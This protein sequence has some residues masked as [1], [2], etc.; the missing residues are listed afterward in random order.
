[1]PDQPLYT[2]TWPP[3]YTRSAFKHEQPP[4]A[5]QRH[6]RKKA[7]QEQLEE[8]YA[9][10]DTRDA[11]R[12]RATG[13]LVHPRSADPKRRREHHHL[14]GR[15]VRP[16]WREQPERIC[17]VSAFVHDLITRGWIAVEGVDA[18][19]PLFFHWTDLATSHPIK[20]KRSTPVTREQRET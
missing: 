14:R 2:D 7:K 18:S 17:L 15:R 10:V 16:E 6:D 4:L 12:C 20:L 8:A 9:A 11:N 13:T 3:R 19:K 1:M 5:V